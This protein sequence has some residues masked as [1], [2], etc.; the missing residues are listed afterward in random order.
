M[1]NALSVISKSKPVG[2]GH[3]TGANMLCKVSASSSSC[4]EFKIAIYIMFSYDSAEVYEV[5]TK[6]SNLLNKNVFNAN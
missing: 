3:W 6:T 2:V 5:E 1:W 4:V